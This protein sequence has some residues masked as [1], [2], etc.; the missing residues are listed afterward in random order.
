MKDH[1]NE[2]TAPQSPH[3]HILPE[4]V[5]TSLSCDPERFR[6]RLVV[7][8][9]SICVKITVKILVYSFTL[10]VLLAETGAV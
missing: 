1:G 7:L 2:N 9:Q 4:F 6:S 5:P 3:P 8:P 10:F